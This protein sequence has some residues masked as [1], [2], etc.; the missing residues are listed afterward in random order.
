MGGVKPLP[1]KGGPGG[2]NV[3]IDRSRWIE[4]GAR[5]RC[6]ENELEVDMS[7]KAGWW[8]LSPPVF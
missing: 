7:A 5:A 2:A 1:V 6:H 8:T 4:F 3:K